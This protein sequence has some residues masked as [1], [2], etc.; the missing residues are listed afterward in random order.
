MGYY[1]K[2]LEKY[3]Q[4]TDYENYTML[5]EN[6]LAVLKMQHSGMSISEIADQLGLTVG[7]IRVYLSNSV[8]KIDGTL[9]IDETRRRCRDSFKKRYYQLKD[10]GINPESIKKNKRVFDGLSA[11]DRADQR[12]EKVITEIANG[13]TVKEVADEYGCSRQNIHSII[14]GYRKRATGSAKSKKGKIEMFKTYGKI[15]VLC[16]NTDS[17]KTYKIYNCRCEICGKIFSQSGHDILKYQDMGCP[18]CRK[19]QRKKQREEE[20]RSHIGEVYGQLEIIGFVGMREMYGKMTP[21]MKCLCH[22]CRKKTEIPL[23]RLRAG[24]AKGCAN[25]ARMNLRKGQEITRRATVG[26]T[27]VTA[28]DG[29]RQKNKNNTSGHNGVSRYAQ[30]GKWR[31]YINFKQKQYHLGLYDCVEDAIAAREAAEKELYGNFLEW[32]AENHPE[33]WAKLQARKA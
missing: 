31:A 10:Q 15:T 23:V 7:T 16:A 21:V 19:K 28:I 1:A 25:C 22:K 8:R 3:G 27:M 32:Y 18:E 2:T 13:K 11:R 5:T 20:A 4:Y 24:Q 30:T 29:K 26:G 17:G 33:E 9:T 14:D 6:E 12:A